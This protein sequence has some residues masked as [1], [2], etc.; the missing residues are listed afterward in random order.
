MMTSLRT[1]WRRALT[2]A[3]EPAPRGL[4]PGLSDVLALIG[5]DAIASDWLCND[6]EARGPSANDLRREAELG[7]IPGARLLELA[8][9]ITVT[10]GGGFEAT[11]L[12]EDRP[13]LALRAGESGHFVVATRSRGLLDDLR[14]RFG[15]N[16]E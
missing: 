14:Q 7:V 10:I 15:D 3:S 11:F 8:A 12:R 5:P 16:S 9:G 1:A 6:V 13:W 2:V 4:A